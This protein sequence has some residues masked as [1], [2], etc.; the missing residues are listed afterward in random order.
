M[1]IRQLDNN[2]V[3]NTY[4]RYEPVFVSGKGSLVYDEAGKE[5]ID[6]ASGIAVDAFG[7]ADD[8]WMDA[9]TA[10]L[11]KLQHISNKYYTA[12]QALLAEALC[13]RTGM[14][15]V[16]F[17]NSGAEANE[18]MIKTARKY[19]HDRCGDARPNIITLKN[20]FHGRTMATLTATGQDAMHKDFGPFLPGFLYAEANDF[21]SVKTLV[22]N[23]GVCGI[24][25]EMIQGEGGVNMLDES[26][27]K[28]VAALCKEK[29]ILLMIDEVQTGNGRTGKLYAYMHYGL[30]PDLVSTAKG[31]GGGLP[32]GLCMMGEKT[33]A[34]LTSGSH[35]STF[36]GNPVCC[37][38]ALSILE[39][40]TDD[41]MAEVMRKGEYLKAQ[42]AACKGV[43][44]VTG[45]G[46]ML[47]VKTEKDAA[48]ISHACLEQGLLIMTAKDKLRLLP[49]LNIPDAQLTKAVEIMKGII[50]A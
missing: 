1:D 11:H 22:E 31:I 13:K 10:Q 2:Y 32:L 12:P 44:A 38:G 27:V 41:F 4:A 18:C 45:M 28:D 25:M 35:G 30:E 43:T 20:S 23:N 15:K 47:G 3:A 50:E 42:L 49:A 7:I 9:V 33:A 24:M 8:A 26:F 14:K 17:G 34:T 40:L 16:F 19:A 39:R 6:L 46:L 37:A 29:D 48:E 21:A 5:Y 36:G